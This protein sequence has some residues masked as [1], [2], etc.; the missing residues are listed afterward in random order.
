[1]AEDRV[2]ELEDRSVQLNLNKKGKLD[3]KI[4]EQTLETYDLITEGLRSHQRPRKR[5]EGIWG[6][7]NI[8]RSNS[9]KLPKFGKGYK[10][11]YLKRWVNPKWNKP[12]EI[13]ADT[14]QFEL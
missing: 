12:K 14:S 4:N 2:H 7:I 13:C 5:W 8:Q 3:W 9:S 1:M 10:P 6:W 11:T